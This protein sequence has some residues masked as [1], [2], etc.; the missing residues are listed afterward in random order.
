MEIRHFC[1]V[2]SVIDLKKY[3]L[4]IKNDFGPNLTPLE[5]WI[6]HKNIQIL[7]FSAGGTF[8]YLWKGS[9]ELERIFRRF[10]ADRCGIYSKNDFLAWF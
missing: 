6:F 4:G 9:Y 3:Q 10:L 1:R 2:K 7:Q 8:N 5:A